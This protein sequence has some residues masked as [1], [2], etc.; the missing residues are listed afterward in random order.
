[1]GRS[2]SLFLVLSAVNSTMSPSSIRTRLHMHAE[3]IYQAF[4]QRNVISNPI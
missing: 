1:M 2:M 4:R 3:W